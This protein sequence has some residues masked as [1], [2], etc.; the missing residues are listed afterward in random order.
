MFAR[1]KQKISLL[2]TFKK[3]EEEKEE[4][5]YKASGQVA[6]VKWVLAQSFTSIRFLSANE[7]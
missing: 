1:P 7:P 4:D 6:L 5:A 3:E 2:F